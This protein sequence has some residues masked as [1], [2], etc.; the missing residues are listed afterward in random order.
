MGLVPRL[1]ERLLSVEPL[2]IDLQ[3][4]AHQTWLSFIIEF[5]QALDS[6]RDHQAPVFIFLGG[7]KDGQKKNFIDQYQITVG[8]NVYGRE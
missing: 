2:L 6:L 8:S 5:I 1:A 3:Q 7:G 4:R